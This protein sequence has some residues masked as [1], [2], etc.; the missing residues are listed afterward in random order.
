MSRQ[1]W[2]LFSISAT[3]LE[4]TYSVSGCEYYHCTPIEVVIIVSVLVGGAGWI[5]RFPATWRKVS[6]SRWLQLTTTRW[7]RLLHSIDIW[8][9]FYFHP[10]MERP[11]LVIGQCNAPSVYGAQCALEKPQLQCYS[12]SDKKSAVFCRL[13][14]TAHFFI[15]YFCG[16]AFPELWGQLKCQDIVLYCI[17]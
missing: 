11:E 10:S 7:D 12:E 15:M 13:S 8:K 16:A 5:R 14:F 17:V 4:M 9:L 2:L 1:F 6:T 3:G